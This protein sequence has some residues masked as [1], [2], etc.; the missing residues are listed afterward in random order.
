MIPRWLLVS[1]MLAYMFLQLRQHIFSLN[2]YDDKSTSRL[3]REVQYSN[4]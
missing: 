3:T 1:A 2:T 4:P